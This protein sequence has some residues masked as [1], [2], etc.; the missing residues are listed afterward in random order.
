MV[1]FQWSDKCKK[2]ILELK[3]KLTTDS[4]MILPDGYMVYCDTSM[5]GLGCVLMQR[6]NV[7]TY[8]SI[9][10]K[11]HEKNYHIHDLEL[12]TVVFA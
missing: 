8:A 2:R 1:K 4:V 9:T 11:V 5:V 7:I 10:L 3:T 12:A 6:G